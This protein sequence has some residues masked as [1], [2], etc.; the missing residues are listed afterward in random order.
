MKTQTFENWQ[1]AHMDRLLERWENYWEGVQDNSAHIARM[2]RS[3]AA[4]REFC[5]ERYE[6]EAPVR[7]PTA[8]EVRAINES[9]ENEC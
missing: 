1:A 5:E 7:I 6:A 4:F 8:D 3:D 2:K 9:L